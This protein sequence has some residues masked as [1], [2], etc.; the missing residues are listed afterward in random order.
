MFVGV[1]GEH[2]SIVS[3]PGETW[4]MT[5]SVGEPSSIVP[6]SEREKDVVAVAS[7]VGVFGIVPVETIVGVPGIV[8]VDVSAVGV[9]GSVPVDVIVGVPGM[10]PVDV[11]PVGVCGIVP[12]ETILTGVLGMVPVDTISLLLELK[13]IV[14]G[15]R[16][17][18]V[19]IIR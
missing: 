15:C 8:P 7:R 19:L 14:S 9:F 5:G 13:R 16:S 11:S 6:W 3:D 12:S 10:V 18:M 4:S 2:K 1:S 17:R